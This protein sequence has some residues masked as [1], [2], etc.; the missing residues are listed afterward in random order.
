MSKRL[1]TDDEIEDLCSV[2]NSSVRFSGWTTE[3]NPDQV[4]VDNLKNGIRKQLLEIQVYPEVIPQLKEEI[5]RQ[6]HRSHVQPGEMVGGMAAGSMGQVNTQSALN[7]FHSSGLLKANLTTGIPRLTELMNMS[8]NLKTP[9]LTIHFNSKLETDI[10]KVRELCHSQLIYRTIESSI[11]SYKIE[12]K[13]EITQDDKLWY[14]FHSQFYSDDWT[15]CDYRLRLQFDTKILIASKKTLQHIVECIAGH[16]SLDR[17]RPVTSWDPV[18][19]IDIWVESPSSVDDTR[20]ASILL[21]NENRTYHF[22]KNVLLATINSIPFSGVIGLEECYYSDVTNKQNNKTIW[23]VDTKGGDFKDLLKVDQVDASKCT[24]NN[25]WSIYRLFGIEAAK[26]FLREEF[27]KNIEVS[28]R[29]LDLLVDCMTHSGTLTSVNRYGID[30]NQVG[31]IAKASFEQ[32]VENFLISATKAERD[33]L[34]SVAA[35]VACGK[36]GRFGTGM[37]DTLLDT[38]MIM[39]HFSQQS[40]KEVAEFDY[41]EEE[42]L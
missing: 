41:G 4:Y 9:S 22:I 26:S 28:F 36:L 7:A 2:I 35:S 27:Q 15:E 16:I 32:P 11:M 25:A 18:G 30:R 29:H 33:D 13:P 42:V 34:K 37:I 21:N 38:E 14:D 3:L 20:P 12:H 24:T 8:E 31:P 40:I 5:S 10:F 19:I 23:Y 39:K 17:L 1:L 6:S